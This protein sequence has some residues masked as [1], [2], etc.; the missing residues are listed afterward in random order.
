MMST[1]QL[2]F[3]CNPMVCPN[4]L[5]KFGGT[6]FPFNRLTPRAHLDSRLL[7]RRT[8][9]VASHES[10]SEGR[11]PRMGSGVF[12]EVCRKAWVT[13]PGPGKAKTGLSRPTRRN[14]LTRRFQPPHTT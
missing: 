5:G 9:G 3:H 6:V 8:K 4:D 1:G 2:R 13:T 14:P 10:K 11:T 12:M 7:T